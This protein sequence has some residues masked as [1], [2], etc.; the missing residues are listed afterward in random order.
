MTTPT[1]STTP[2]TT[3][4]QAT[5]VEHADVIEESIQTNVFNEVKN[6]L[7]KLLPQEVSNF[8]ESRMESTHIELCMMLDDMDRGVVEPF[9]QKKRRHDDK[10]Q[11][12]PPNSKKEKKTQRRKDA[13]PSKK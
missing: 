12:P 6:Q 7:P 13:K 2:P 1:P 3:E 9:T 8:V 10:D 5:I 4:A 11:D